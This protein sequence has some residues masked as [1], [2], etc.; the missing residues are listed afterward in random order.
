MHTREDVEEAVD[1]QPAAS[2]P[3][4]EVITEKP[5]PSKGDSDVIEVFIAENHT[6]STPDIESVEADERKEDNVIVI[7]EGDTTNH[8]SLPSSIASDIV[9]LVEDVAHTVVPVIIAEAET[10]LPAAISIAEE[11]A[12][13]VQVLHN[14]ALQSSG[15]RVKSLLDLHLSQSVQQDLRSLNR[16]QLLD[17][18]H[19][20][21]EQLKDKTALEAVSNIQTLTLHT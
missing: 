18:I 7:P 10:L 8:H 11:V 16:D 2:Q 13:K 17:R 3:S 5:V 21:A 9:V 14:E 6:P 12:H 15:D 20:L 4:M 19:L 1:I